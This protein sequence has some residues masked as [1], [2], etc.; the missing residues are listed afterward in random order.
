MHRELAFRWNCLRL[1]L[2]GQGRTARHIELWAAAEEAN[3]KAEQALPVEFKAVVAYLGFLHSAT[4]RRA[5]S[6]DG[7]PRFAVVDASSGTPVRQRVLSTEEVRA[8]NTVLLSWKGLPTP[9]WHLAATTPVYSREAR[10]A[11]LRPASLDH[12][13]CLDLL[14]VEH[15]QPGAGLPEPTLALLQEC[16]RQGHYRGTL[17]SWLD[18][19]PLPAG[20]SVYLAWLGVEFDYV[21]YA[22]IGPNKPSA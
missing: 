14:R 13:D 2:S 16:A 19:E 17:L 15:T 5:A 11:L 10:T 21:V 12:L 22:F 7:A 9:W 4:L 3:R 18:G 1:R 6:P 20:Q 8:M